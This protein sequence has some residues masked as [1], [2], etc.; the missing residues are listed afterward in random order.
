MIRCANIRE[1]NFCPF[2]GEIAYEAE[3]TPQNMKFSQ[4]YDIIYIESE[5][6]ET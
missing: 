5:R 4:I 1:I 6:G 2:E 3:S